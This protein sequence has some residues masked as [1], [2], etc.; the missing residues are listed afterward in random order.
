MTDVAVRRLLVVDRAVLEKARR[1]SNPTRKPFVDRLV[2]SVTKSACVM[3]S[4][5][6]TDAG[7]RAISETRKLLRT[8]VEQGGA[9]KEATN[10]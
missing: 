6:N 4:D 5:V 8:C 2:S 10:G 1:A 3:I 9:K 7:D